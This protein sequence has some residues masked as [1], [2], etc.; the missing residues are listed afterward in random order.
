[1]LNDIDLTHINNAVD[2]NNLTILNSILCA[3]WHVLFRNKTECWCEKENQM[4]ILTSQGKKT[5]ESA[6]FK[7]VVSVGL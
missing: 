6:C 7:I 4:Q 2:C 3:L 5:S 1:M